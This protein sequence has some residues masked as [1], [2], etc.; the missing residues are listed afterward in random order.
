MDVSILNIKKNRHHT[1][2]HKKNKVFHFQG[3]RI[4]TERCR[5]FFKASICLILL[6][7]FTNSRF[8]AISGVFS[9]FFM[10]KSNL[11]KHIYLVVRVKNEL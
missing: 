2:A 8:L 7:F 3:F 9:T 10:E 4:G 11:T 6:F 1:N 5:E